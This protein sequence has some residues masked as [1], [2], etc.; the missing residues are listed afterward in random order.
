MAVHLS[1]GRISSI[2][3]LALFAVAMAAGTAHYLSRSGPGPAT[4]PA[5]R[6]AAA[7]LSPTVP[8]GRAPDAVPADSV[9]L[10]PLPTEPEVEVTVAPDPEVEVTVA[11]DPEVEVTVAPEPEVV[12][13]AEAEPEVRAET[14]TAAVAAPEAEV[15]IAP[16]PAAV[17]IASVPVTI[18][19][20]ERI[21]SVDGIADGDSNQPRAAPAA[22]AR[23]DEAGPVMVPVAVLEGAP[24]ATPRGGSHSPG[25]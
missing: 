19:S 10:V 9:A 15:E 3:L 4:A 7:I 11:P 23:V 17:Q 13:A 8:A 18:N 22:D 5:S 21:P 1:V 24:V 2:S 6:I 25:W 16:A 14:G 20:V 12:V